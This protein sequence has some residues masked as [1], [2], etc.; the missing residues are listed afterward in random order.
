MSR[1]L[2]SSLSHN[3]ERIKE[4]IVK[5]NP[6]SFFAKLVLN[7]I[8]KLVFTLLLMVALA[9]WTYDQR[10]HERAQVRAE[11]VSSIKIQRPLK[12]VE[13][14]STLIRQ[15]MLFMQRVSDISLQDLPEKDKERFASLLLDTRLNLEMIKSY[16][17][18][19]VET[20]CAAEELRRTVGAIDDALL[21]KKVVE[22]KR[23]Q[24]LRNKL[25]E[26]FID[27]SDSTIDETTA[28]ISIGGGAKG[29]DVRE[30]PAPAEASAL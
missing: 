18:D 16:S 1:L 23:L 24:E 21:R 29:I 19:R 17:K 6:D 30:C 15:C 11:E 12:L 22:F 20:T 28:V 14:L 25:Y 5:L 10:K 3:S 9:Y 8:D 26:Q 7:G 13:E 2:I 27:L 4:A